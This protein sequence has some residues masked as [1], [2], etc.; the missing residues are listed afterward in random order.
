MAKKQLKIGEQEQIDRAGEKDKLCLKEIEQLLRFGER[1]RAY[2]KP[3]R[4]TQNPKGGIVS[5]PD[6][7]GGTFALLS[8]LTD[9][10]GTLHHDAGVALINQVSC[11]DPNRGAK[12]LNVIAA[13]MQGIA[14][15]DE[16]EGMLAA[17]MVATHNTAM[18]I[19]RDA[20]NG[21]W[22]D[23]IEKCTSMATKLLRTFTAQM[24]ALKKYRSKG[25]QKVIVEHV[26]VHQGGQAIVGAITQTR[27]EGVSDE[28][29]GSTPCKGLLEQETGT[30]L[31]L[32]QCETVLCENAA[33]DPLPDARHAKREM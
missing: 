16:I 9:A 11:I 5:D 23:N 8:A 29:Q 24:E 2:K 14:P 26:H 3:A 12:K 32:Q 10:T 25:E 20:G 21:K 6:F 22:I 19:L 4:L 13:L 18:M 1:L 15:R 17:Q 31:E 28:K 33:G 30:V 7:P 27:G